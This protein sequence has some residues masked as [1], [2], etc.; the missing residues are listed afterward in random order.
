MNPEEER[1]QIER[2]EEQIAAL[3]TGGVSWVDAGEDIDYTIDPFASASHSD[4]LKM[5]KGREAVGNAEIARDLDDKKK[6]KVESLIVEKVESLTIERTE[7]ST[8]EKVEGSTVG[9][10]E[11]LAV[12]KVGDVTVEKIES[13]SVEKAIS[14]VRSE[15]QSTKSSSKDLEEQNRNWTP[16]RVPTTFQRGD[17]GGSPSRTQYNSNQERSRPQLSALRDPSVE[18]ITRNIPVR[19]TADA[20]TEM[21]SI[22]LPR[23]P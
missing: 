10:V 13:L 1:R 21:I 15:S 18:M 9:K 8:A 6:G 3:P 23:R 2:L 19:L 20:E 16:S 14:D 5:V 12:G 4:D 22:R 7:G 11:S 17:E